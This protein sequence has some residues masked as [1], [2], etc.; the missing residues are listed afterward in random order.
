MRESSRCSAGRIAHSQSE[1]KPKLPFDPVLFDSSP[2][3]PA[4]PRAQGIAPQSGR[5][6]A[7][8][9]RGGRPCVGQA[10]AEPMPHPE[11]QHSEPLMDEQPVTQVPQC[12]PP[13]LAAAPEGRK[14]VLSDAI[15]WP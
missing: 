9:V 13:S 11:E 2:F 15:I 4:L 7:V 3:A 6:D 8:L 1:E 10:G 5:V 12:S 14:G